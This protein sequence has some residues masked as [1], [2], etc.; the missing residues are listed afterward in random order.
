MSKQA[1]Y[2]LHHINSRKVTGKTLPWLC[3]GKYCRFEGWLNLDQV[4]SIL[5]V[6][7]L[8]PLDCSRRR[9]KDECSWSLLPAAWTVEGSNSNAGKMD[10]TWPRLNPPSPPIIELD[11][12]DG[13][14]PKH[15]E[16]QNATFIIW[17]RKPMQIIAS[18]TVAF[19]TWS[20]D[21]KCETILW[22]VKVSSDTRP[23]LYTSD[24]QSCVCCSIKHVRPRLHWF[25]LLPS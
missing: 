25:C 18:T 20:I 6:L 5:P 24:A 22:H 9:Q 19:L 10:Q 17:R 4:W 7:E 23:V 3:F 14:H 8:L 11:Q 21:I 16:L 2:T 12:H 1:S 13:D 15:L